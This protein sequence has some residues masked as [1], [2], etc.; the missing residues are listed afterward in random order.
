MKSLSCLLM[1]DTFAILLFQSISSF[2]TTEQEAFVWLSSSSN[3]SDFSSTRLVSVL[4]LFLRNSCFLMACLLISHIS[5]TCFSS[6]AW[7]SLRRPYCCRRIFSSSWS[8]EIMTLISSKESLSFLQRPLTATNS[9]FELSFF[10]LDAT[11]SQMICYYCC[12]LV[13]SLSL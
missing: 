7:L 4:Y 13:T 5:K 2:S 9:E 12:R 11:V 3:F 8:S 1:L 6:R 10:L